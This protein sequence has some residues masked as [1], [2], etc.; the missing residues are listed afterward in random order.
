[1]H[2]LEFQD[3]FFLHN[4]KLVGYAIEKSSDTNRMKYTHITH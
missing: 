2:I 1:M 4:L 3:D